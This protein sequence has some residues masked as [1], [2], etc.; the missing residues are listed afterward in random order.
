MEDN[1]KGK[2]AG[3][4]SPSLPLTGAALLKSIIVWDS[5]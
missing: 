1:R 2:A 5:C 4:K 3:S